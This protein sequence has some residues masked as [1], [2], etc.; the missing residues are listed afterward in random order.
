[1]LSTAALPDGGMLIVSGDGPADREGG[2]LMAVGDED[3]AAIDQ[4]SSHA[5]RTERK[6][7]ALPDL[8]SRLAIESARGTTDG[9]AADELALAAGVD[10]SV[11]GLAAVSLFVPFARK[12]TEITSRTVSDIAWIGPFKSIIAQ[13]RGH[14]ERTSK[15]LRDGGRGTAILPSVGV[16]PR[17]PGAGMRPCLGGRAGTISPTSSN[18]S[19]PAAERSFKSTDDLFGT[20]RLLPGV[21]VFWRLA[22]DPMPDGDTTEP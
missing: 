14:A 12:M 4:I 13:R 7:S 9:K 21:A 6:L 18:R 10:C 2:R 3:T 19:S 8:S 16:L 1:M 5:I 15:P 20:C 17:E 22:G 11:S